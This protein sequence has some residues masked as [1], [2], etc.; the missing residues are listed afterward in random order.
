M[1]GR[2]AAVLGAVM[3][4][5]MPA[6]CGSDDEPAAVG[7]PAASATPTATAQATPEASPTPDAPPARRVVLTAAD[8]ERAAAQ[9][10]P[11][12]RR[13]PAVVL[14]HEIR[15]GPDQWD[16]LVPYLH[17]AGFATLAYKSRSSPM[18]AERMPDLVAAL[19]WL[20]SRPRQVDPERIGLVGS[21]IGGSTTVLAM[22]TGARKAADAAVALSPPDS[23]DIWALQDDGRYH[24]HDVLFIADDREAASAEDMMD[25]AVRS[26]VVTTTE[27]GHGIV[28]LA[29][30]EIRD[31]VVDW[32]RERV[33]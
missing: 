32:L 21:S 24:P 14:L 31:A 30:P 12:G 3:V 26:E 23:S 9:F 1:A 15:G 27:R 28:L 16:G 33:S 4:M 11:A 10:T 8:G 7:T 19:D 18:E 20:R 6:G 25:G 13:A 5:V 17:E 29:E 2:W 22:A